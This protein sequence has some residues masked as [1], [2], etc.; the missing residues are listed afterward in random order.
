MRNYFLLLFLL[1]SSSIFSQ[2]KIDNTFLFPI[3]IKPSV[4]GSFAEL[5][6]NHFHSGIDLSTNGKT[7]IPI[8]SMESGT[9][10][11]I[12]VSPVGYGNAIYIKHP[13]GY[14]TVYGH[15]KSYSK[16]VEEIITKAQYE[17]QSFAID[18]FPKEE[19]QIKK[20]EVIG[21]SGN[22]GSSGGP[23]LH[24]EIRDTE[25]EEPLNPFMF[26]DIIKD[27]IRPHIEAI[28]LYPLNKDSRINGSTN[29]INF[30]AVF[31]D[32]KFH[33]KGNPTIKVKGDI[34]VA[35]KMLDYMSGSWK[36]CGVYKLDLYK[37]D[38]PIYGWELFRFSF[39]ESRYL[40]SHIDYS[41]KK[42]TGRRYEKCFR[43]QNN[44]LSIYSNTVNDGII[45]C[46]GKD[47]LKF[48]AKDAAG[49]KSELGFNIIADTK[50][51]PI[52]E[53][54]KISNQHKVNCK[55]D[56]KLEEENFSC[57]IPKNSLYKNEAIIIR[58]LKQKSKENN[59]IF[60]IGDSSIPLHTAIELNFN[61]PH[62]TNHEQLCI[63]S[64]SPK[65]NLYY[66]GGNFNDGKLS[67][68]TRSFGKY[69]L[70]KDT[71]PPSISLRNIPANHNYS[72]KG[73]IYFR[74]SDS[75]SGI[76][77][78]NGF[79][80][81][82]WCLFEYDAKSKLIWCKLDKTP[83]VKGVKHSLELIVEDNCNNTAKKEYSFVY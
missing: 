16:K 28:R 76:K 43:D 74:I 62:S 71:V 79:I 83:V 12:K 29:P 47:H 54:N 48:I 57:H 38:T 49:N 3:D 25:S 34:G 53:P 37:N 21:F 81:G 11:R 2:K 14:T 44:K 80:D 10:S 9:I 63:A 82:K 58:E 64:V 13:N 42:K 20:G 8:K 33:L 24:Y 4:S 7:G 68:K 32:G 31:Y 59:P 19:I 52:V 45:N 35:I 60:E 22:S 1:A 17:K 67:L 18:Y 30:V 56:F 41:Y 70:S 36:K 40:N 65:G 5:R 27:D 26:Q 72:T 46:T 55:E 78:Y 15:L 51:Y 69:T 23:H 73:I 77:S 61:C 75:Y 50:S 66:A 39:Y 6:S